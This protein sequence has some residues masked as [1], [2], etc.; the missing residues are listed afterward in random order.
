MAKEEYSS[1]KDIRSKRNTGMH[2]VREKRLQYDD[3]DPHA[4]CPYTRPQCEHPPSGGAAIAHIFEHELPS[5]HLPLEITFCRFSTSTLSNAGVRWL[6]N[7]RPSPS[8]FFR[9]LFP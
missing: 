2:E 3:G 9:C 5:S 1:A 6:D 7:L 8:L 4:A